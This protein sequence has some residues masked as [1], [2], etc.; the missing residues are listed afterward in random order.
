VESPGA[1]QQ[2]KA[3]LEFLGAPVITA[4]NAEDA[5]SAVNSEA[6]QAINQIISG[7]A[8]P[9]GNGVELIYDLARRF[10]ERYFHGMVIMPISLENIAPPSGV[11]KLLERPGTSS[12]LYDVVVLATQT[13]PSIPSIVADKHKRSSFANVRALIAEDNQVNQMVINGILKKFDISPVLV[14][15]GTGAVKALSEQGEG[16]D[17]V[18]MDC[19]MPVMDGWEAAERIRQIEQTNAV[20]TPAIIVALSAHVIAEP[21]E[22]ALAAGMDRFVAKP[23]DIDSVESLLHEYF[24]RP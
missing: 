15:D 10:P 23:V 6:G 24:P 3:Q 14:E 5:L 18:F 13:P 8:L 17:L 9:D 12:E 11:F 16:F 1:A 7:A 2:L 20:E 19:E 22:R 4:N 21:A